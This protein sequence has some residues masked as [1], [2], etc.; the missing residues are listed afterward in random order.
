VHTDYVEGNIEDVY[1]L[2]Q[3]ERTALRIVLGTGY[4][5]TGTVLDVAGKP[6]TNALVKVIRNDGSHRKAAITGADGKF[7]LRGLSK[8]LTKF[9]AR[10]LDAGQKIDLPMAVNSDK[11]GL[12]IRLRAMPL[13]PDLRKRTVLGVELANVTPELQSAYDLRL[14][15]GAVIIHAG[16]DSGRLKIGPLAEGDNFWLVGSK[17]IA[18]VREFVDQILAEAAG[19]D[20]AK[21]ADRGVRVVY[22]YS[23]VDGD[24]NNTQYLRLTK[25]DLNELQ[26]VSNQLAREAR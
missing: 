16:K 14:D 3:K 15:R 19:Q 12:E 11:I 1:A 23:R 18:S 10:A 5:L 26:S 20:A 6:V 22:S 17:R 7:S 13:P 8:G 25:E 9:S 21:N 2:T 4:K 24:G